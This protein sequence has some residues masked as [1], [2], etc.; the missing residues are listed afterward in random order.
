VNDRAGHILAGMSEVT[1][2]VEQSVL[3]WTAGD[4]V[5]VERSRLVERLISDGRVSVIG[6]N[7]APAVE[8][9]GDTAVDV[10]LSA[11]ASV[12]E[13]PPRNASAEAW[14]SFLEEKGIAHDPSLKRDQLVA[15]WDSFADAPKGAL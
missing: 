1:L 5:T 11:E 3:D 14:R 12:I 13:G 2:R 4:V 15:L 7:A 8:E 9:P 10:Q 6:E